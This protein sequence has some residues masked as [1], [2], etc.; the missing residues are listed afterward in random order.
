MEKEKKTKSKKWIAAIILIIILIIAAGLYFNVFSI[1][2][3]LI[4]GTTTTEETRERLVSEFTVTG[5]EVMAREITENLPYYESV[6]LEP[7]RYSLEL[8]SDKPVWI[9]VY[10]EPSFN[11]W[12][13]GVYVFIKTGT[14]CCSEKTKTDSFSGNFDINKNEEGKYYI[15][16]DGPEETLIKFKVTQNLKF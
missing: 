3:G 13:N 14:G 16:I 8:A 11:K 4:A 12:K 9:M 7:G 10:D 2:T 15:V 6:E 1:P 5:N